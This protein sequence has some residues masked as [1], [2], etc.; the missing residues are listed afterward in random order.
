M[1]NNVC[2]DNE[3]CRLIIEKSEGMTGSEKD[4]SAADD[5]EGENEENEENNIEGAEEYAS[6][7]AENYAAIVGTDNF[8]NAIGIAQGGGSIAAVA[9]GAATARG[10]CLVS[11][12]PY[13]GVSAFLKMT[14]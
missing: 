2:K 3:T 14:F 6:G 1:T 9:R 4:S 12:S 7:D 11:I 8:K 5:L 13:Q 10:T